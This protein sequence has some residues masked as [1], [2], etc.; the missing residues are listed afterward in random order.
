MNQ[1]TYTPAYFAMLGQLTG[2]GNAIPIEKLE[3]GY[4][5]ASKVNDSRTCAFILTTSPEIFN[6]ETS[7]NKI[8]FSDFKEFK[9]YMELL[10]DCEIQI[11]EE[12]NS[13]SAGEGRKKVLYNL[14]F[15]DAISSGI[16]AYPFAQSE[17]ENHYALA[18]TSEMLNDIKK[19]LKTIG[20]D[21]MKK[22]VSFDIS[23][24]DEGTDVTV[25]VFNLGHQNSWS[26]VYNEVEVVGNP[27]QTSL[28]IS[29]EIFEHIPTMPDTQ[30]EQTVFIGGVRGHVKFQIKSIDS[31]S[32]QLE[33]F[34]SKVAKVQV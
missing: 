23:T 18:Y 13:L 14:G 21:M 25:R 9:N 33:L 7:S 2:I 27:E 6:F 11:D 3:N 4:C 15:I 34:C 1:L 22:R 31:D 28:T 8:A 10:G 26:N 19:A 30:F 32:F 20:G 16:P 24:T 5:Q 12:G 17:Q 29:S